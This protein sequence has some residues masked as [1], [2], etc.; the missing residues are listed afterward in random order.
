FRSGPIP[1]VPGVVEKF[2]RKGWKVASGTIDRD[3]YMIVTPRVREEARKYFDCDDLE[4]AEL[5]NQMGYGTRGAHWEKRV[6]EV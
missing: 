4:G 2:T 5:E 1:I 3:V 6:F